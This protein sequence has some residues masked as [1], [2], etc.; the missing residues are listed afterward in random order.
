MSRTNRLLPL[1]PSPGTLGEGRGEGFS[2]QS[3]VLSPQ[4][5]FLLLLLLATTA[6]AQTIRVNHLK[7]E[8]RIDPL[9]IDV[10]A[11]RL[12]WQLTPRDSSI[13]AIR[14]TAYEIQAAS[15]QTQLLA[16]KADLW[17]TGKVTSDQSIQVVYAGKPLTS[18]TAVWWR[19]KIWDQDG[20]PSEWSDQSLWTMGLLSKPDWSAQWIGKDETDELKRPDSPYWN[21]EKAN[22]IQ[23][24]TQDYQK[25]IEVPAEKQLASA[26][27]VIGSEQTYELRINGIHADR[28][29]R[30]WMA[31]VEQ[32]APWLHAGTNTLQIHLTP[33]APTLTLPGGGK[34]MI[35]AAIKL[36]FTDNGTQLITTDATWNA[37]VLGPYHTPG[38]AN[39]D[40]IGFH[41]EHYLP[42][43][44]LRKEFDVDRI[45]KRAKVY[46]SGLGLFELHLNGKKVSDDVLSPALSQYNKRVFYKT[47]D[48]TDQLQLGSNTVGV[49]LGNGRFW[50]PRPQKPSGAVSFGYPKLLLQLEVEYEDGTTSRV[51]SDGSWKLTTAGPLTANN[52]YDGEE[53]DATKEMDG[54]DRS[55]FPDRAWQ[56]A[57]LVAAPEGILAAQM[58]E[59]MR[60]MQN[61]RPVAITQPFPGI[62]VFDMGQNFVGWCRLHAQGASGHRITLRYSERLDDKGFIS[63]DNLRA[64]KS[65]DDYICAAGPTHAWEPRFTYHGFRYVQVEGLT[66]PP[67]PELLDGRVVCD[68]LDDAGLWQSSN[69]TLNKIQANLYWGI[70]GN[71]RSIPTDCPQRDERQG[72]LGDRSQVQLAETYQF[73]VAAFYDKW[74][75]DIVDTQHPNGQLPSV[76]P[77]YWERYPDDI[78]WPSTLL[79][80]A[81]NLRR[82]YGD[83]RMI[84]SLYPSM[85]KW[86][87]YSATS[88]DKDGLTNWAF[89]GDW[90]MPSEDATVI[91]S[92]EPGRQTDKTLL[93]TAYFASLCGTM[94][95]FATMLN[96]PDDAAKY[97]DLQRKATEALNKKFYDS[98]TGL[99]SNGSQTSSVLPLGMGLTL[100]G[101]QPKIA[102]ALVDRITRDGGH[103]QTGVLGT[104]FL[105]RALTDNNHADVAYK[106]AVEKSYPSW[107]YMIDHG[108]TTFWELWNGNTADPAMNSGNHVM[109]MGDLSIWMYEDLAGIRPDEANPGFKHIIIHPMPLGDLTWL[110]ATHRSP[111][112]TIMS[113]WQRDRDRFYIHIEVPAN[114]TTTLE[115]PAINESAVMESGKPASSAPGVKFE[116]MNGDRAVF[117]VGSGQYSFNSTFR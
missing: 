67:T 9:G 54:W 32:I 73:D 90:C 108:A 74:L 3:S 49:I 1:P 26:I 78:T 57:A 48:V 51:I 59:P 42:A 86:M 63:V 95:Q 20:N 66:N 62:Y 83:T 31:D 19:V 85:K 105:M 64:A 92:T 69:D 96:K 29:N 98:K 7:C 24:A 40:E 38:I 84:E 71:Y 68:N 109:A 23:S 60:V 91:H 65:T 11:P 27:L 117:T 50:G 52:E 39:Y 46:V 102:Q 82:Q 112:G 53:Y 2:S 17:D 113:Q 111:Y 12:Q 77:S 88:L 110:T 18:R 55:G 94:S 89:Y 36:T 25:T 14:Q 22:W 21:I 61:I 44:Y 4:H 56:I 30:A 106:I 10:A 93:G 76:A 107:G 37:T 16:G 58:S 97:A 80:A 15:D 79:Y 116:H 99:Y 81:S 43:R 47:Y 41:Q 8:Y 13:R 100:P 104:A 103:L 115:I 101:E 87:E 33:S 75:Q 6:S 5:L 34:N 35:V 114:T 70:R 28:G 72:W 45:V